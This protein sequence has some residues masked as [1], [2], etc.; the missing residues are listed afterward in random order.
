MSAETNPFTIAQR[1]LDEADKLEIGSE[2]PRGTLEGL[3]EIKEGDS[4]FEK[5]GSSEI[6]IKD[7]VVVEVREK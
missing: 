4:L 2:Y 3:V 5:L 6:V 7:G 1:Q